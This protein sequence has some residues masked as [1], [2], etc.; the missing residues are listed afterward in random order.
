MQNVAISNRSSFAPYTRGC[1]A[2]EFRAAA[3]SAAA[4][5]AAA[6][7]GRI[8]AAHDEVCL[9][10]RRS[11]TGWQPLSCR[12]RP[13]RIDTVRPLDV[14]EPVEIRGTTC[15][16][17]VLARHADEGPREVRQP[18]RG[19]FVGKNAGVE[20]LRNPRPI[21]TAGA[22]PEKKTVVVD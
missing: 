13:E 20:R 9:R 3:G 22:I 5:P 17:H 18:R 16:G 21:G 19:R 11:A 12:S 8:H 15:A 6:A 2:R 14:L 4:H 1:A 7:Y 10:E